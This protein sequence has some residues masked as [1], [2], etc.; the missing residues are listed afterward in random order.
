MANNPVPLLPPTTVASGQMN[1]SRMTSNTP[2][3]GTKHVSVPFSIGTSQNYSYVSPPPPIYS[4]HG[5]YSS[6]PP[7]PPSAGVPAG[8]YCESSITEN[9]TQSTSSTGS[10]LPYG[11]YIPVQYHWCYS[12]GINDNVWHAFSMADSLKLDDVYKQG[13]KNDVLYTLIINGCVYMS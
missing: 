5:G 8:T 4:T 7:H 6:I 11:L 12:A 2:S 9:S 13:G 1:I 3:F 10:F